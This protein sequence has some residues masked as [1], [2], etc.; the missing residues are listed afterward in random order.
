MTTPECDIP[1]PFAVQ[2]FPVSADA[3]TSVMDPGTRVAPLVL[4]LR[5][6]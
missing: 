3:T 5:A 4:G 2:L 1:L 6:G